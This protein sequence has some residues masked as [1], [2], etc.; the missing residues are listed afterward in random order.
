MRARMTGEGGHT[1]VELMVAMVVGVVVLLGAYAILDLSG[2]LGSR[3]ADRVETVSRGRDS[4]YRI[5]QQLASQICLGSA[6]P[7]LTAAQD[8]QVEFFASIA[9]PSPDRLTVQ[10]RRLTYRPASR[11]MLEE[12]WVATTTG[13]NLPNPTRPGDF[14]ATPVTRVLAKGIAPTGATPVF[15]YYGFDAAPVVP[16]LR[17]VPPV[18]TADRARTVRI[19]VNFTALGTQSRNNTEFHNQIYV[20]TADPTDP[21]RSPKCL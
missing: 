17:F 8:D 7:A 5:T 6:V 14:V 1:L 10:R 18:S 15:Q 2:R 3:N 20:R 21:E 16:D 9:P 4:M 19:E 12:V 11:D 13:S